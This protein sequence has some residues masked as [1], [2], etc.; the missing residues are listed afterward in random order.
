MPVSGID[1]LNQLIAEARRALS[2]DAVRH[3]VI[4]NES[5]DLDSMA[6]ALMYAFYLHS[7]Q[8]DSVGVPIPLMNIPRQDFALRRD[9]SYLFEKVGIDTRL[10][11]F[12]DEI[13]LIDLQRR[14]RLQITLVDHNQLARF[15]SAVSGSVLDIVDHHPDTGSFPGITKRLIEPVGSTATL[16]A[17]KILSE[18]SDLLDQGL[19]FLL[20]GTIM[21]DTANLDS[22]AGIA[23]DKDRVIVNAL[24]NWCS[25]TTDH[26]YV[27]LTELKTDLS[28]FNTNQILRKDFKVQHSGAVQY[29]ISSVPLSI[30]ELAAGHHD[31]QASIAEF[32]DRQCLD[33]YLV[34]LYQQ[35]PRFKR[36]L[37]AYSKDKPLMDSSI[38][39]LETHGIPLALLTREGP[40]IEKDRLIR[41][42]EQI[43]PESSRKIVLKS[44]QQYLQKGILI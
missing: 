9:V 10:L 22:H 39:Y 17:E 20:L 2:S 37:I 7:L 32:A 23:A 36:Q 26:L 12:R 19:S 4:G 44:L 28:G 1:G 27:R 31:W 24:K 13:D 21:A 3:A 41:C 33:L 35:R 8:R 25:E 15:Q 14:G 29:G 42:Y 6:S 40:R 30:Q 38:A 16:V 34:M 43:N 18:C 5:A 11:I